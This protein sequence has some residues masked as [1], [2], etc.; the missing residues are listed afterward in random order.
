MALGEPYVHDEPV[1]LLQNIPATGYRLPATGYE[2]DL[3]ARRFHFHRIDTIADRRSR[4]PV[5]AS[6]Q[7]NTSTRYDVDFQF[8]PC[9]I[10]PFFIPAADFRH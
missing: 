1:P 9:R 2:A 7:Q 3:R 10:F 4:I 8:S 5:M 6:A